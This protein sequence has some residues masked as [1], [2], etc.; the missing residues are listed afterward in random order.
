MYS[1]R[2]DQNLCSVQLVGVCTAMML[3]DRLGRRPLLLWG[4][5]ISCAAMVALAAAD[6]LSNEYLL[7]AAMCAFIT[8][9]SVSWAS[10]FWVL[11]SEVGPGITAQ[12]PIP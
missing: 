1:L 5:A 8:A 9:F 10:T 7:L 12:C 11:M 6:V 4:S 3:I 2:T